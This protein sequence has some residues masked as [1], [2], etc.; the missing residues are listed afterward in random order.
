MRRFAHERGFGDVLGERNE[1]REAVGDE[2]GV[3]P[4]AVDDFA[5]LTAIA[6]GIR[7]PI[8]RAAGELEEEGASR[9]RGLFVHEADFVHGLADH[10]LF[11]PAE[12][13]GGAFDHATMC[14]SGPN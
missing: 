5:V 14:R 12:H 2:K 7:F 13:G 1:T 11:G 4:A 10:V 6:I 8:D 9:R 3:E